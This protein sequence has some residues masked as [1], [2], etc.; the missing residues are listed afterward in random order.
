MSSYAVS[1]AIGRLLAAPFKILDKLTG[2]SNTQ[3][4]N[5]DTIVTDLEPTPEPP[6][7]GNIIQFGGYD[8]RVLDVQDG[9]TLIISD[10][11]IEKRTFG[12][13]EN[14]SAFVNFTTW[15]YSEIREYLNGEFYNNFNTT[16]RAKIIPVINKNPD[17]QWFAMS[18]D[19]DT[20]DFIFLLSLDEVVQYFGDSGQLN[21]NRLVTPLIEEN[22]MGLLLRW[23]VDDERRINK[24]IDDEYNT[25]RLAHNND[26]ESQDWWLRSPAFFSGGAAA[27]TYE[28]FVDVIGVGVGLCPLRRSPGFVVG[29]VIWD[30]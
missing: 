4:G 13:A 21:N 8:W 12:Y 27:V 2:D 15:K 25:A 23:W 22:E 14:P 5:N 11:I 20:E 18:G 1:R 16:E 10:K 7:I 30:Y 9:K 24:K 28:G 17:N 6:D 29:V 3:D 26:G 19:G